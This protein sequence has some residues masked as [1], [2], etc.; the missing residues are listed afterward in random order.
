MFCIYFNNYPPTDTFYDIKT[1]VS[2]NEVN[3]M[4]NSD[5][6]FGSKLFTTAQNE[7]DDYYSIGEP[8]EALYTVG[9]QTIVKNFPLPKPNLSGI[10]NYNKPALYLEPE[11]VECTGQLVMDSA[12]CTGQMFN[13]EYYYSPIVQLLTN[14]RSSASNVDITTTGDH[15]LIGTDG[16]YAT[17][18]T[19]ASSFAGTT[20]TSHVKKVYYTITYSARSDGFLIPTAANVNFVLQTTTSSASA[21]AIQ[22]EFH[23]Y[24]QL[25]D[26]GE[27]FYRSGNPGY[28]NLEPLL[29]GTVN[30]NNGIDASIDGFRMPISSSTCELTTDVTDDYTTDMD[31]SLRWNQNMTVSCYLQA[32]ANTEAAFQ[33]LCNA[34][35]LADQA[36]FGQLE[37][38]KRIGRYGNANVNFPKDWVTVLDQDL[39]YG[40]STYDTTSQT[41]TLI[42]EVDVQILTSKVGFPD[43]QHAYVT[44]AR[45]KGKAR[46]IKFNDYLLNQ[47]IDLKVSFQFARV[48]ETEASLSA[49]ESGSNFRW[50]ADILWPFT[51]LDSAYGTSS[52]ALAI[53]CGG[54][55]MLTLILN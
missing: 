42:T 8:I 25:A 6:T 19:L 41:C 21:V 4:D 10:C 44:T 26:Q 15:Y 3:I 48:I 49:Y 28:R 53:L 38:F 20:C 55:L 50:P 2:S 51:T 5:T 7:A 12:T 30:A 43:N 33:T 18:T 14:P 31:N 13:P 45:K 47:R 36:I 23:T 37:N 32:T 9:G 22:Q 52:T 29:V 39:N 24:Y 35:A 1:T 11:V 34:P 16:K 54:Y 46:S 40:T 17:T 27:I